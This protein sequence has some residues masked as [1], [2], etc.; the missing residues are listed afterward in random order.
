MS[1]EPRKK[2]LMLN[3]AADLADLRAAGQLPGGL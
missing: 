3:R 1:V 2:L